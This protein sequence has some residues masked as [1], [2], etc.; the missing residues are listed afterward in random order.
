MGQGQP[1]GK[2]NTEAVEEGKEKKMKEVEAGKQWI[3]DIMPLNGSKTCDYRNPKDKLLHGQFCY[4]GYEDHLG[5]K[6]CKYFSGTETK[7]TEDRGEYLVVKC[8]T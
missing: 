5:E 8:S 3:T 2:G 7:T 4:W 1:K 6:Q